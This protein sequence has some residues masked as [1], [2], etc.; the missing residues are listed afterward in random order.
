MDSMNLGENQPL[1]RI[2]NQGINRVIAN[3]SKIEK[4]TNTDMDIR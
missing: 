1:S 3:H 4:E 2:D